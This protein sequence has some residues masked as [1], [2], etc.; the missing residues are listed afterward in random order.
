VPQ[1]QA[2][3][4][5]PPVPVRAM[6]QPNALWRRSA[7]LRGSPSD[8][9]AHALSPDEATSNNDNDNNNNNNN[10]NNN[11][12]R[13]T[14]KAV[15]GRP[16]FVLRGHCVTQGCVHARLFAGCSA[17]TKVGSGVRTVWFI[18]FWYSRH[19]SARGEVVSDCGSR[20][21]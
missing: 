9:D 10:N 6:H 3:Q 11:A 8:S 15:V 21:G 19:L 18:S 1:H 14:R 13:S 5:Q 20:E 16:Y 2:T 4:V 17:T 7:A 12:S